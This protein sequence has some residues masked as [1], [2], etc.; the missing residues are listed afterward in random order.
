MRVP[1]PKPWAGSRVSPGAGGLLHAVEGPLQSV[2]GDVGEAEGEDPELA[3]SL[4]AGDGD[5]LPHPG[6]QSQQDR[7]QRPYSPTPDT[8]LPLGCP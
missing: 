5:A 3:S 4:G 7:R 6:A 8:H 1:F 2:G